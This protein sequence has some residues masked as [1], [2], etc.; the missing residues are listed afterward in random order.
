MIAANGVTARYLEA[1]GLPFVAPSPALAGPLGADRQAG[2]G[3]GR[4]SAPV[5]SV[6]ALDEFLDRRRRA[7]PARFPDVSL[8]VV[9]LLGSGE[10]VVE[11]PGRPADGH[12][13]LAVKDYT[14][15][16]APNRRYPDLAT[17]RLLKAALAGRPS[18]YGDGGADRAGPALH[19]AGGRRGQGRAAGAQVCGRDAAGLEDRRALRRHRDRRVGEG[20]VGPHLP[21]R[22]GR[23]AAARIRRASMSAIKFG[24]SSSTP[25]SSAAS[26]TSSGH[27]R[28]NPS[29]I[30]PPHGADRATG[31]VGLLIVSPWSER[32]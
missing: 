5:P 7:D 25:T 32:R 12:F 22:R 14:H 16:T 30:E 31:R 15:S 11:L 26:S 29:L 17:Q 23:K 28:G 21:T 18:P 4:A 20:D 1:E 6:R 3:S 9:K 24:W 13:G 2:R 10:Y 19:R 27:A 8:S